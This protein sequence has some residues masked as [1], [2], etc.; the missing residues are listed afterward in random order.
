VGRFNVVGVL[1]M[2]QQVGPSMIL[3][4]QEMKRTMLIA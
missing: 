3:D 1:E 2:R 4:G